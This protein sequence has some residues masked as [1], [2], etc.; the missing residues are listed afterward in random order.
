MSLFHHFPLKIIYNTTFQLLLSW[1]DHGTII[2]DRSHLTVV[3]NAECSVVFKRNFR[4]LVFRVD[5]HLEDIRANLQISY[6]YP[7]AVYIVIV[8]ISAPSRDSLQGKHN[9][10]NVLNK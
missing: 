3:K 2:D 10:K 4:N 9:Y 5:R 6:V 7:L 1:S 8:Y